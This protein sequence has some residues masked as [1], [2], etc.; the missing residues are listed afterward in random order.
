MVHVLAHEILLLL[1]RHC[2][3]PFNLRRLNHVVI[4]D[5]SDVEEDLGALSVI[6]RQVLVQVVYFARLGDSS[7]LTRLR[8]RQSLLL[9]MSRLIVEEPLRVPIPSHGLQVEYVAAHI[10][11][12]SIAM[13]VFF[14][15]I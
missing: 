4:P 10:L 3:D 5:L 7:H 12:V 11:V 2:L 1:R 14:R 9:A 15:N 13:L 6:L 8:S